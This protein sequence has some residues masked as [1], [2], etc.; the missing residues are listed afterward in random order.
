MPRPSPVWSQRDVKLKHSVAREPLLPLRGLIK[1]R[2]RE[3]TEGG[4]AVLGAA[5]ATTNDSHQIYSPCLHRSVLGAARSR[6]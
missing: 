6:I 1:S 3:P 4:R 2:R 5:A